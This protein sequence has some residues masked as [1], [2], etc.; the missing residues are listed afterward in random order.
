MDRFRES[1]RVTKNLFQELWSGGSSEKVSGP[2]KIIHQYVDMPKAEAEIK[3]A[4]GKTVKVNN[5]FQIEKSKKIFNYLMPS[6]CKCECCIAKRF[7]N[8]HFK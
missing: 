3:N 1:K 6:E 2:V 4:E 7:K 8:M 5:K